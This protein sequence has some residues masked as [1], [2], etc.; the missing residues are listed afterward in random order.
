M[1]P[2]AFDYHKASTL[3][4]ALALLAEFG[5]DGRPLAG[6]QSLVPMMNLRL[7]R[8]RHLVDINALPL[9]AIEIRGDALH[10]G[11]LVRHERYFTDPL[12]AEHFP[13]F[14]EAVHWIGHPT[15][16]RHGTMGG[17]VS[18]ADPTAEL[19]S[20]CVL[21]DAL[22]VA[23]SASGERRIPATEFFLNAY[24]T[25]L[26]PGEMVTAVEFP[27]PSGPTSGAFM[28]LGERVG[29]FA[30][31]G[32]GVVLGHDGN[33]ITSARIVCSGARLVPVRSADVE[34]FLVGRTLA[35]PGAQEA[36]RIFSAAID[37]VGDHAAS[38]AYRKGLIKELT[39]RCI[40]HAAGKASA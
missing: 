8:P 28:E 1:R 31:A 14:L 19:P 26:E 11:A 2:S 5:D 25:A 27:L 30:I 20:V 4:Q 38:A 40:A 18:H 13:A 37:P 24:V 7:A 3:D 10:I 29:D 12:I 21:H 9:D 16:R 34:A 39:R 17:S 6:G 15:I 22:I 36:G 35:D 32:I 23:A 33:T